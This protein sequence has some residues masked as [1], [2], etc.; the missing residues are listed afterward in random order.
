VNTA[1]IETKNLR[2]LPHTPDHIRALIKG[3]DFYERSI[4][5]PTA[6][7][8]REFFASGEVSPQWLA[9][10]E[11]AT[12]TDTWTHG[13]VLLHVASGLVIG[14]GGFKGPPGEDGAVEI[15]YGV[16]PDFQ[17]KG[18]ATEA[19]QA[20]VDYAFSSD[21]VRVARA[22]TLPEMNAST[23][24]LTKCGFKHVGEFTDPEDGLVWRWEK[25]KGA[26]QSTNSGKTGG[27]KR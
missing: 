6:P 13:F 15:A 11:K 26:P 20:L 24:V 2:L 7:G 23:R 27:L 25:P 16:V 5:F 8:L 1:P 19:A 21:R 14:A 9:Q 18:Y 10:V 17:G 22:H 3:L 12:V 4:G